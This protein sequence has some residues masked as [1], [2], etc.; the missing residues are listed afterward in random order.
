MTYS[1]FE[2]RQKT[3]SGK[4]LRSAQGSLSYDADALHSYSEADGDYKMGTNGLRGNPHQTQHKAV[5]GDFAN[6]AE[7]TI[8][9]APSTKIQVTPEMK[10]LVRYLENHIEAPTGDFS[11]SESQMHQ[12][13]RFFGDKRNQNKVN[14]LERLR[15]QDTP[16]TTRDRTKRMELEAQLSAM[17]TQ[18]ARIARSA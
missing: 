4:A 15:K 17:R 6:F 10:L 12:F 2:K 3:P 7:D 13:K 18:V 14:Q 9:D 11:F 8:A 1:L 5:S 16:L